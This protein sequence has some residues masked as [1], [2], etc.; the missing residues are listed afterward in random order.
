MSNIK[1]GIGERYGINQKENYVLTR[2]FLTKL[3]K[4]L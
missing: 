1:G 3:T 4:L 2:N